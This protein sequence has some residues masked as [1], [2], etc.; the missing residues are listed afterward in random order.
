MTRRSQPPADA[1]TATRPIPTSPAADAAGIIAVVMVGALVFALG[2]FKVASLDVGYHVAYGGQ[3]LD[4]GQIVGRDPF[5][6]PETARPFVNANWGSQVVMAAMERAAGAAGLIG[7]RLILIVITFASVAA[8]V[9]SYGLGWL[10][11]AAAWMLA[12]VAAYER[13]SMRP[14]LFSYALMSLQLL[15]MTRGVR[16]WRSILALAILQ[17]VWVNV[18][19][20][21]VVGLLLTMAWLVAVAGGAVFRSRSGGPTD[22][23]AGRRVKL[24]AV[25][26][27]VQICACLIN[28]WHVRGAVF[29]IATLGFLESHQ[30]M[31]GASGDPSQSAWSEIS[32]FQ[33][34]FSFSGQIIN[35]RTIHGYWA[36][37]GAGLIG[38][39]ALVSR[40]RFGEALVVTLLFL[41]SVKMRRNIAQFALIGAPLSVVG[42]ALLIPWTRF[43]APLSRGLRIA[44]ATVLVVAAGWWLVGIVD[45]RFYYVERRVSREFGTGYSERTFPRGAV[46][47]LAEHE[48]LEPN[49]FVD[50]FTSSNT[51]QWLPRRFKLFVDTNTFAYEDATLSKAFKLGLGKI[52]HDRFFEAHKI[53]VVL[54]H[55]GPDTQVLI[56]KMMADGG[57]WALVYLDQYDVVFVRRTMG[58]VPIILENVITIASVDAEQWV[59]SLSGPAHVRALALGTVVNVPMS[60]GWWQPAAALLDEAV[61]LAPDY[62][63]A[64]YYLGVCHGNLGNVAARSRDY[65]S[66][67]REWALSI[68]CFEKVLLLAP[69]H[70][71][72]LNYL[73]LTRQKRSI[74]QEL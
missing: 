25:C 36:L 14:E 13:F 71:E 50:Y 58:H 2:W 68:E 45:G 48:G 16:S 43:R 8:V 38:V 66:A 27:L 28:P 52:D 41:M 9:R 22:G 59:G 39:A 74:M 73:N 7:L 3:F 64:W 62:Y 17:V 20:Y 24:L 5:L 55:C 23:Q 72:S 1:D 42:L 49:L 11:V 34:P 40:G 29:P 6:L 44:A 12:A 51:L 32:E 26:L 15:V 19:S 70:R 37:L 18:H 10:A 63:E 53:N 67:D 46:R 65:D 69:E 33:S 4:T 21:F 30:A 31:G 61:K 56:R 35:H 57:E 47:W 54:L 60:L